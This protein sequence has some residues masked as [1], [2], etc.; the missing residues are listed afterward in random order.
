MDISDT[1]RETVGFNCTKDSFV[2]EG[3]ALIY[4][5][6]AIDKWFSE[7]EEFVIVEHLAKFHRS[8]LVRLRDTI[9]KVLEKGGG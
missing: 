4:N 7:Q 9:D 3:R 6:D 1:L 5:C 8:G 2:F